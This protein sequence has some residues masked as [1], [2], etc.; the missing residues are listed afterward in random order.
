MGS[1]NDRS[2]MFE[3]SLLQERIRS[4]LDNARAEGKTLGRPTGSSTT[5]KYKKRVLKCREEGRSYRW[6]AKDLQISKNTVAKIV[7]GAGIEETGGLN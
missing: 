1:V 6:I 4:G 7:K 2:V 3:R 5:K